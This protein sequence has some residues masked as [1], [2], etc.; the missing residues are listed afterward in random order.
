MNRVFVTGIGVVSPIGTGVEAFTKAIKEGKNGIV[1]IESFDPSEHTSQIGG[2]I[3]DFNPED[4]I[5]DKKLIRHLD[6]YAQFAMAASSMAAKQAKLEEKNFD[7]ERAGVIF[8]TGIGG[9][10]TLESEEQTYAKNGPRRASPFLVPM[11]ICDIAAGHIAMKYDMRGPNFC[12]VSACASGLHGIGEAFLKIAY[13]ECDIVM[14]GAAEAALT[15]LTVAGFAKMKALSTRNDEPSKASRP[16]DKSRNGFVMGEGAG[17]LVFESEE[18][19]KRRGSTILAEVKGYG[20]TA[21]AYHLTAPHPEGDGAY[22]AMMKAIRFNSFSIERINYVNSHGTSTPLG[23]K[24]E[25][26]AVRRVFG[27]KISNVT[28]NSTKSMIGHLL[29]AAGAV[30]SVAAVVQMRN[31]FIHPTVNLDCPDEEFAGIDFAPNK[32]KEKQIDG[33][34]VNAF[35]FGGHNA[36]VLYAHYNG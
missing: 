25:I 24:A 2:E 5:E 22:A 3:R 27:D 19:A 10:H 26:K 15:P 36:C 34:L 30:G 31:G 14:T 12:T 33:A 9:I 7:P 20:A 13:G 17:A 23:D 6:R 32:F 18:S 35:G 28:I 1:K 21:D 11:M 8:S 4:F 16:F 29:G